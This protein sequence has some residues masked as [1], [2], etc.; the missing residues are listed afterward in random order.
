MRMVI[1]ILEILKKIK[2]IKTEFIYGLLKKKNGLVY[3]EM[4]YGFWKDNKRDRNGVYIWI[5]EPLGNEQF[6]SANFDAYVGLI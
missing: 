2:E 6:D 3:S 4:Y 1:N 5:D